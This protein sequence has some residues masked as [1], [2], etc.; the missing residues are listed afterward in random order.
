MKYLLII[1]LLPISLLS[2]TVNLKPIP[3]RDTLK[4]DASI[5]TFESNVLA[6]DKDPEGK[7]MKVTSFK[8]GATSYTVNQIVYIAGKGVFSVRQNGDIFWF[9]YF[10]WTGPIDFS[11]VVNDYFTGNGKSSGPCLLIS[12][13]YCDWRDESGRCKHQINHDIP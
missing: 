1:I 11:Y 7:A 4:L 5:N 13:Y 3:M 6:N 9:P 10:N 8:I 2:Q 12:I